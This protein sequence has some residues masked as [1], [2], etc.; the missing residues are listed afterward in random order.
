MSSN[1]L[2]TPRH[3]REML[4]CDGIN[5]PI[6]HKEKIIFLPYNLVDS[7][8]DRVK[9]KAKQMNYRVKLEIC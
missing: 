5:L 4:I 8:G 2:H 7:I 1:L 6:S 9:M 3:T